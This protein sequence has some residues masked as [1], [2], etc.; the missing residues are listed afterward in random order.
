MLLDKR[1]VLFVCLLLLIPHAVF[2]VQPSFTAY[3]PLARCLHI[4][5][6]MG[7]KQEVSQG[8]ELSSYHFMRTVLWLGCPHTN[9]FALY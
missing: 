7:K 4:N 8:K 5:K 3:S 9:C 6:W 1:L 2:L